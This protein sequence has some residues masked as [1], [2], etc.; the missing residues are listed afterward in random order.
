MM[1]YPSFIN[2]G[3]LGRSLIIG[4]FAVKRIAPFPLGFPLKDQPWRGR[5]NV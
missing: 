2:P 4:Y 3:T 1:Y 5:I